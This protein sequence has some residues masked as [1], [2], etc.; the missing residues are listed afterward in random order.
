[1]NKWR[2]EFQDETVLAEAAGQTV[3]AADVA[4]RE[5]EVKD[6]TGGEE[7]GHGYRWM[8]RMTGL[9]G[10]IRFG[11]SPGWGG[12]PP[13]A[14]YLS[15][16]GQLPQAISWFQQQAPAPMQPPMLVPP[17]AQPTQQPT[18]VPVGAQPMQAPREQELQMLEGQAKT[19]ESQLKQIRERISQLRGQK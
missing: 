4:R 16:T 14:Q 3:A 2:E 6:E 17:T 9:P 7:M 5:V 8:F 11:F 12:L 1:V 13:M 10:W 18:P 19:L 15:Q